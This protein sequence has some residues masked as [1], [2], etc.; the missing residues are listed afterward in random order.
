M[1]ARYWDRNSVR[2]SVRLSVCLSHSCFVTN[3]EHTADILTPYERVI[4]LV[5]SYQL[6]SVGDVPFHLKVAVK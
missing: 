4:T 1:L 6:R 2:P 5:F 3:N